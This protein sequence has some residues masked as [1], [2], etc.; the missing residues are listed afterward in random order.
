M[1]SVSREEFKCRYDEKSFKIAFNR[2]N[3]ADEGDYEEILAKVAA[4]SEKTTAVRFLSVL[5]Q[6]EV[7]KT[8]KKGRQYAI[9]RAMMDFL[10]IEGR[11]FVLNIR[12]GAV[13][14]RNR[15]NVMV[16]LHFFRPLS[17]HHSR[18]SLWR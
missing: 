7:N 8:R 16:N 14:G 5:K 13:L 18:R 12:E 9:A 15:L 2:L 6:F 1:G 4:P 10:P 3:N 11:R 17:Y